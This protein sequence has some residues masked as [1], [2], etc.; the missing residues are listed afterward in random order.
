MKTIRRH[1]S[2]LLIVAA[3][4]VATGNAATKLSMPDVPTVFVTESGEKYHNSSCRHLKKSRK[5]LSLDV[6]KKQ[7]Y[8]PCRTCKPPE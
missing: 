7:G 6:A 5:E 1:L 8:K 2:L 4:A 3:L